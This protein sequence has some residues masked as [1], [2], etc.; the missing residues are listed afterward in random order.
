LTTRPTWTRVAKPLPVNKVHE[1][2]QNRYY[3][4]VVKWR[5]VE[6]PGKHEQLIS[7]ATF[8][9]VQEILHGHKTAGTKPQRHQRYLADRQC[10][11]RH[12]LRP[13]LTNASG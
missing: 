7:L 13:R 8:E 9:H 12:R 10:Y 5:G 11:Q 4:G 1:V 6:Y 2:L 3:T